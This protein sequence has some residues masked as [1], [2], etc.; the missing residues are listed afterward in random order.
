M[1]AAAAAALLHRRGLSVDASCAAA[2]VV[3]RQRSPSAVGD[4]QR[5]QERQAGQVREERSSSQQSQLAAEALRQGLQKRKATS[6]PQQEH[7]S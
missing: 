4:V 5:L 7:A 1:A 6:L 3:S 2:A